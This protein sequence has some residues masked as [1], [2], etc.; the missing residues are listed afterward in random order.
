MHG[1]LK[2]PATGSTRRAARR[3]GPCSPSR[4]SAPPISTG[5]S[6]A[7]HAPRAPWSAASSGSTRTGCSGPAGKPS[8]RT[9]PTPATSPSSRCSGSGSTS[10]WA[11]CPRAARRGSSRTARCRA[12]PRAAPLSTGWPAEGLEP[13]PPPSLL[14]PLRRRGRAPAALPSRGSEVRQETSSESTHSWTAPD[15][16]GLRA[17]PSGPNRPGMRCDRSVRSHRQSPAPPGSRGR[18]GLPRS[19]RSAAA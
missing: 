13:K 19:R 4:A 5:P 9:C 1:L 15:A 17:R 12:K 14:P 3:L 18:S 11:G 7:S 8:G 10:C 2:Q 6:P 16:R